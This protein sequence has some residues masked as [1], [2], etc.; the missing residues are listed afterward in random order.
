LKGGGK[1]KIN[2]KGP[3][4]PSNHQWIYDW[5]D[6]EGTSPKK[7]ATQLERANTEDLEVEINSG[8]GSVFDASEIYTALKAYKGNVTIK[9]VGVAAS[10]ASV[11][12][13]AGNKVIMSPTAQMMIHNASTRADGDYRD[14]DRSSS[15]LKNTNQ[16]IANAYSIKSGKSYE[17]L[18]S[19]MDDETWLTAQQALEHKLIDEVMFQDEV[20]LVASAENGGLLPKQVIDKIRNEFK[21]KGG[22]V[23]ESPKYKIENQKEEGKVM[24][25]EKLKNDYPDLYEQVINKGYENGVK[26]ERERIQNIEELAIPGHEQL[27]NKAKFE[28]GISAEQAAVEM[29]KANKEKGVNQLINMRTDAE[30]L[31]NLEPQVTPAGYST[32]NE[33]EQRS[34]AVNFMTDVVKNMRG[35]K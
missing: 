35:V 3:I 9:I 23:N 21:S 24:D 22:T 12:A 17:D 29:I 8:G 15:M 6:M 27:L 5:L 11:I 10:A 25:F 34:A 32:E 1:V 26:S 33:E 2:I 16:T 4:I 13:M 19:M 7:V 20:Q 30:P 31:Q 28:S 14:M 18:L